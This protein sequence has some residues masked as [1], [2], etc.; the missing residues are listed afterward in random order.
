MRKN[1]HYDHAFNLHE[2]LS[3]WQLQDNSF[4]IAINEH[5]IPK[6]HYQET[7]L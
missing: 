4:A 6:A 2:A 5:F 1:D 3:H 7:S